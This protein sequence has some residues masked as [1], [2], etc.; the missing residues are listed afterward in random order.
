MQQILHFAG[1]TCVRVGVTLEWKKRK[2]NCSISRAQCASWIA[3]MYFLFFLCQTFTRVTVTASAIVSHYSKEKKKQTLFFHTS[4]FSL[5]RTHLMLTNIRGRCL[6]VQKTF[7]WS[8]TAFKRTCKAACIVKSLSLKLDVVLSHFIFQSALNRSSHQQWMCWTESWC[9]CL[10]K[11][12]SFSLHPALLFCLFRCC[13]ISPKDF[14]TALHEMCCRCSCCCFIWYHRLRADIV[15][16]TVA[17][18]NPFQVSFLRRLTRATLFFLSHQSFKS[19]AFRFRKELIVHTQTMIR[20]ACELYIPY[21][22]FTCGQKEGDCIKVALDK[23][24]KVRCCE[25][26]PFMFFSVCH[27]VTELS[28]KEESASCYHRA[29]YSLSWRVF[30]H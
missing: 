18:K 5:C 22:P 30:H 23:D 12:F 29:K 9:C 19:V 6:G 2:E 25:K 26:S 11:V 10:A 17:F 7:I 14:W 1:F 28:R 8:H 3:Q 15:C 21:S 20:G 24:L 27:L 4:F 16:F 13:F